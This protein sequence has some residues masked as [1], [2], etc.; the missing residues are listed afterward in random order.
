MAH[1][2]VETTLVPP[3]ELRLL[4]EQGSPG[5]AAGRA[6]VAAGPRVR[7]PYRLGG[8]CAIAGDPD[9]VLLRGAGGA[10]AGNGRRVERAGR[11]RVAVGVGDHDRELRR[12][13]GRGLAEAGRVPLERRGLV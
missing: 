3:R 11:E 5:P 2:A 9:A 12:G 8:S 10:E 4:S 13:G 7:V 6:E 1:T